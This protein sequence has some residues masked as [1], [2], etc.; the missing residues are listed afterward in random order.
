MRVLIACEYNGCAMLYTLS[1]AG[2]L[3]RL[4]FEHATLLWAAVE[5][6]KA[7]SSRGARREC[8]G[9]HPA[10]TDGR[11]AAGLLRALPKRWRRNG[12]WP[13]TQS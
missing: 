8:I 1:E 4:E 12:V 7:G 3:P 11:N 6:V 13:L 5:M 9:C 2:D 10:R